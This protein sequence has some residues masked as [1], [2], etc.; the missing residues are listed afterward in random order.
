MSGP[1]SHLGPLAFEESLGMLGPTV[2]LSIKINT[3]V[4]IISD[5]AL[6]T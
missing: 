4:F 5:V 2:Q 6:N 3:N 1:R